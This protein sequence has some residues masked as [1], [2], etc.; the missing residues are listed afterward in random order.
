MTLELLAAALLGALVLWIVLGPL[1]VGRPPADPLEAELL[2]RI[3][4][5]EE[6]RKGQA[7]LAIRDLDFDLATGKISEDDHAML[8]ERFVTEALDVMREEPP[9]TEQDPAE[10][11]VAR[12][13][14][15]LAPE[16]A[17][18]PVCPRC[19]PRPESDALFCSTCGDRLGA[20]A[21][22]A[23]CGAPTPAGA[24]FCAECGAPV[25]A[26]SR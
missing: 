2:E 12:R 24:R 3:A 15:L 9:A 18:G 11:L 5:A 10:A 13:A 19:G 22:C 7:L 1:V 6:T 25:G 17:A 20:G 21:P 8:R 4:P 26:G 16:A 14:A 23:G